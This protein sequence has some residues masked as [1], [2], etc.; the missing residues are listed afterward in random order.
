MLVGLL[1]DAEGNRFHPSHTVKNGKRYCYYFCHPSRKRAKA[2]RLP[3]HDV[4]KQVSLRLQSFLRSPNE[5]MKSLTLPED[6]P[7]TT[8]KLIAAAQAHAEERSTASPA[9]LRDFVKKV[10]RRIII[11]T[12]KMDVE[13]S[14]SELR[15]ILMNNQLRAS[16]RESQEATPDDLVRLTLQAR[17]KRCGNEMRPVLSQDP[18]DPEMVTPIV[19]A[20]VRAQKWRERVLAGDVSSQI[21]I[22]KRSDANGEYL[23]RVLGC[24]FL[25][26]D[27]LDAM[28]DGHLPANLKETNSSP[29]TARLGGAADTARFSRTGLWSP[30]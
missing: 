20:I 29:P 25:A 19:K 8:Q 2:I 14:R 21:P 11:Q 12:E 9:A 10:V 5:V 28:L 3:A 22:E 7:E 23:R 6:H 13:T 30:D 16:G 17:L 4:E 24:A 27:I 1:Q 26:P 18:V 15:A